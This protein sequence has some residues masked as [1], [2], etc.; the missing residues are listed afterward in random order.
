[1]STKQFDTYAKFYDLLYKDKNYP[2]E[3]AYMHTLIGKHSQVSPSQLSLLDLACGTGKHL[4][5][6]SS[7]GYRHLSGSDI[8]SAMIEVAKEK[9]AQNKKD[10]NFYNF[11]FQNSHLIKKEFDVV[12]SMFSAV[13]YLTN[14][15]D[16][17]QTFKNVNGLLK[18]DG[19]FIFDYWNGNAVVRDYSPVKVLRKKNG[20]AEII[21]ISTTEINK[22][23]QA[24][25]V[26]F[27]C[28]YLDKGAML[29]EFEEV[30]H[31]HYYH[32]SEI[33]N[34]LS[35]AGFEILHSSPFLSPEKEIDPYDWNISIVAR[36]R[37][38]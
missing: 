29:D 34:L 27:N 20:T 36:K 33:Y 37:K 19:L 2:G 16:Q 15:D 26:K 22:V 28:M 4:F 13:N 8:S 32:F 1:M 7:L 9:A 17:L 11:S 6:L 31:L 5:E 35:V 38:Q 3:A 23:T 24:V 21:R 14:F 18:D 30:H 12:I 10:I 25:S